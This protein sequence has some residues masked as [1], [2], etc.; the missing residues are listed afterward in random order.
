MREY[1][2]LFAPVVTHTRPLDNIQG[3]FEMLERYD[4]GVGK[5]VLTVG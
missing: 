1:P 5:L 2:K 4:D 3:A